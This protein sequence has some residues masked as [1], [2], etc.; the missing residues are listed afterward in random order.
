MIHNYQSKK[1][2]LIDQT[3]MVESIKKNLHR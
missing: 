1:I 2:E 3:A